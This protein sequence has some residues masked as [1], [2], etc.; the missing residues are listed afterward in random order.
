LPKPKPTSLPPLI[1]IKK[2]RKQGE[3]NENK[4]G[5]GICPLE[6]N[7]GGADWLKWAFGR[8]TH[9]AKRERKINK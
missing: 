8:H 7:F 3:K 5:T 6:A 4:M 9:P 1:C 2:K